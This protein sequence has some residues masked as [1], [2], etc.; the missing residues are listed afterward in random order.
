MEAVLSVAK[1]V[2]FILLAIVFVLAASLL[3]TSYSYNEL[4]L[5]KGEIAADE[6]FQIHVVGSEAAYGAILKIEVNC[7]DTSNLTITVAVGDRIKSSRC[8]HGESIS[9]EIQLHGDDVGKPIILNIVGH[10]KAEYVALLQY[11]TPTPSPTKTTLF[12][13]AILLAI[14]AAWMSVR[15]GWK[16]EL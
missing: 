7:M 14:I 1:P 11:R 15:R 3:P 13:I 6:A 4:V 12:T 2:Y 8:M 9:M 16:P 5:D 10:G